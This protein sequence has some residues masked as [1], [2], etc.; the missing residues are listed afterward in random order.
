[1]SFLKKIFGGG[2]AA[3]AKK[4]EA[5]ARKK[6]DRAPR[7]ALHNFEEIK[8]EMTT[9]GKVDMLNLSFTGIGLNKS[10]LTAWPAIGEVVDC[11][12]T[13]D[14]STIPIKAKIVRHTETIVGGHFVDPLTEL[15][16][17]ITKRFKAEIAAIGL[18]SIDPK[19]LKPEQDGMPSWYRGSDG[20]EVFC[21]C[22]AEDLVR[23]H[24]TFK[25]Y[26]LEGGKGV[27]PKFHVLEKDGKAY[28][29]HVAR[30]V[31]PDKEMAVTLSRFIRSVE[32]MPESIKKQILIQLEI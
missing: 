22:Q 23:Y 16:A 15:H 31:E 27:K 2:D 13:I 20:S 12:I 5:V 18:T 26:Y 19:V 1:M 28:S 14:G 11:K 24:M 6:I 7:V 10:S 8:F 32:G 9:L 29:Q 30:R 17:L 25:P 21:V 3:D 4:E